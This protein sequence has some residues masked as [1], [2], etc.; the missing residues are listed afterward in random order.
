MLCFVF[1]HSKVGHTDKKNAYWQSFFLLRTLFS[2]SVFL[3]GV[4]FRLIG[5][6]RPLSDRSCSENEI[7]IDLVFKKSGRYRFESLNF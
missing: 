7:S 5:V 2:P 6:I 4:I 1:L 3:F